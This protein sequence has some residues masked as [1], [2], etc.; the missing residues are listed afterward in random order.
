MNEFEIELEKWNKGIFRGAKKKLSE[1]IKVSDSAI[2]AWMSGHSHP[3]ADKIAKIAKEFGKS[4][5]EI[6]D[7]FGVKEKFFQNAVGNKN[8]KG[9]VNCISNANFDFLKKE[10]ET[11]NL[12]LD[13]ILEKLKK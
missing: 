4:E 10:F 8:I 9:N 5:D 11:L 3:A 2:S 7:I 13:L 1:K 6:K 12:K